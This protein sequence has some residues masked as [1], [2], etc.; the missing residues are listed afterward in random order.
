M[1]ETSF[2]IRTGRYG[3]VE[4]IKVTT[5]RYVCIHYKKAP[6]HHP[7]VYHLVVILVGWVKEA[8]A[9]FLQIVPCT[10]IPIS[11]SSSLPINTVI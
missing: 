8:R 11:T 7:V 1:G 10:R 3:E 2:C 5:V 9:N 6:P 4:A